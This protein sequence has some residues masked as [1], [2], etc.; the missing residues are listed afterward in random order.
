MRTLLKM[1]FS[2]SSCQS[3]DIL[4]VRRRPFING[5]YLSTCD[6]QM[7]FLNRLSTLTVVL[8]V[9]DYSFDYGCFCSRIWPDAYF[10]RGVFFSIV[11]PILR[12]FCLFV[13]GRKYCAIG[14]SFDYSCFCSRSWLDAYFVQDFSSQSSC[15]SYGN[16]ACLW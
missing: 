12:H 1:Y 14:Y 16:F 3:Y 15:Q 7:F 4:T 5:I 6:V 8:S 10:I 9:L 13:L 11:L 2:Q